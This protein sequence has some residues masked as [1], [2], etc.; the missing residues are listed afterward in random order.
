[1]S[2]E[3]TSNAPTNSLIAPTLAIVAGIASP[4]LSPDADAFVARGSAFG[5]RVAAHGRADSGAAG[6]AESLIEQSLFERRQEQQNVVL[7]A[8]PAHQAD[9]PDLSLDGAKAAGDFDAEF[10]E[11]LA[12]NFLIFDAWGDFHAATGNRTAAGIGHDQS[13]PK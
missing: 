3:G 2:F 8:R 13:G 4:S 5:L 11:K 6:D 10:V 7:L 9:A 1:M 12:A